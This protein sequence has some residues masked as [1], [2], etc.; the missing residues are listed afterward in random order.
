MVDWKIYIDSPHELALKLCHGSLDEGS[1]KGSGI[2]SSSNQGNGWGVG[3]WG[4]HSGDGVGHGG[5]GGADY[6]LNDGDGF[7]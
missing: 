1:G 5:S 6:G 3:P 7:G 4:G 2:M